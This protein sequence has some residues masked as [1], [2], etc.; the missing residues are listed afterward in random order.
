MTK[1]NK[2]DVLIDGRNFT[3]IGEGS[4]EYIRNLASYVDEKIKEMTSKNDKLS[5]SM[6]ATLAALNI[7]DELYKTKRELN[8]LKSEA[9]APM[10]QYDTIVTQLEKAKIKIKELE[11]SCN[12]YKDE[13]L[14]TKRAYDDLV[15]TVEEQN[16]AL[17]IKEKELEESQRMIKKLQEKIFDSQI[18]LIETKKE[19]EEALKTFESESNIFNKE[20][21]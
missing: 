5:A 20:E 1:K 18:E 2:V 21:I 15:K 8:N 11:E 16:Q 19:L 3:V 9:K 7:A 12:I 17:K 4:E 13:L 14:D 6:A 10:E